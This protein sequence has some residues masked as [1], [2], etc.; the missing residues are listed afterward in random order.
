MTQETCRLSFEE[1]SGIVEGNK[2]GGAFLRWRGQGEG[3]E[4]SET[5][6][7][8][9]HIVGPQKNSYRRRKGGTDV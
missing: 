9:W 7:C 4:L 1:Q 3:C 5:K 2:G 8:A 6:Q